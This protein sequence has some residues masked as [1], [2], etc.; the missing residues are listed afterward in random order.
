MRSCKHQPSGVRDSTGANNHNATCPHSIVRAYGTTYRR[1]SNTREEAASFTEATQ[2]GKGWATTLGHTNGD[3]QTSSQEEEAA[4][5][6]SASKA[7]K[8]PEEDRGQA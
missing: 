4:S 6:Y 8:R 1:A 5:N 2:S 7:S 3:L